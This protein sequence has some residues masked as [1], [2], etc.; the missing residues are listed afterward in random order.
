MKR[1]ISDSDFSL[2]YKKTNTGP[3]LLSRIPV[4][5][6]NKCRPSSP[7]I[8]QYL[9]ALSSLPGSRLSVVIAN[10]STVP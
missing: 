10:T 2:G 1:E 7:K 4:A 9:E 8:L 5:Q 3:R 6:N